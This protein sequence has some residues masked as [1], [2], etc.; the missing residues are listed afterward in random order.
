[1]RRGF[2]DAP[3]S[4]P[5]PARTCHEATPHEGFAPNYDLPNEKAYCETCASLAVI[6]WSHRLFLATGDARYLDVTPVSDAANAERTSSS[7]RGGYAGSEGT[8]GNPHT[9][10]MYFGACCWRRPW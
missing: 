1:M 2:R 3:P 8:S 10:A 6:L 5:L 4:Q 9:A 7:R